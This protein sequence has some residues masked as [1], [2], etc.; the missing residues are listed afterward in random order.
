[1]DPEADRLLAIAGAVAKGEAV[2]WDD[3]TRGAANDDEAA[4][5]R[6]LRDLEGIVSAHR[7]IAGTNDTSATTVGI[8]AG[9]GPHGP[10]K[11]GHLVILDKLGEGSFGTVYRAY[12]SR[13]A[14]DVALK[15]L[16][17]SG[18]PGSGDVLKEARLLAKVRHPNVVTVF[19]VD[20]MENRVGL[21]MELIKGRTLEDLL[22]AQGPFGAAEA[23][24]I[25]RDLCRAVAAVHKAGVVHGD[26]KARNVMRQEGGRTVLMDFGA[27]HAAAN[28][29]AAGGVT[30]T[31]TPLYL[32]PE[33]VVDERPQT[34]SSDIYALGVLLY[35]LVTGSFPVAG[36]SLSAIVDAHKRGN[37]R[38]LRDVRPDLPDEFVRAVEWAI[39]PDPARRFASVGA[40]E[41]A[42]AH[43]ATPVPP[44]PD[45]WI[46]RTVRRA[47]TR[48]WLM[49]LAA[50]VV[51]G[52]GG[53]TWV[54]LTRADAT[55]AATKVADT[56]PP[57]GGATDGAEYDVDAA[58]YRTGSTGEELLRPGGRVA[59]GDE[60]F[61]KFQASVPLH[62]YVV[63]EDEQGE[64]FLMFP[65]PGQRLTNPIRASQPVALPPDE[66]KWKVTS[67]G[68][69]EHFLVFA[70]PDRLEAFEQA[71]NALPA[72]KEGAPAR[73][74]R[75]T[76]ER[77]R[78]VGGLTPGGAGGVTPAA[79]PSGTGGG[80]SRLFTTPLTN[81]RERARG[82]WVRQITLDNPAR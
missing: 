66:R 63:N 17:P 38:L 31:G 4:A 29:S 47:A 54:W 32:A 41:S 49:L 55:S 35:H 74:P 11:W 23:A 9:L 51:L 25:G 53:T 75:A 69:R 16:A 44:M 64:Q 5:L 77:L 15:L 13:L 12:D 50:V 48:R 79:S 18:A 46:L 82:L 78:G 22:R 19:G 65:L 45:D 20:Q 71:F 30:L 72:P 27:G 43:G 56:P 14:V 73:L 34:V 36:S 10:G 42:L 80:L 39:D 2:S 28:E 58:F 67:A 59:P 6:G 76:V 40:L 21:W 57:N 3:E 61:L 8:E 33:V 81:A 37:R 26:I 7:R 1:M 68:G 70:S 62:L 24:L 60:L 52:A